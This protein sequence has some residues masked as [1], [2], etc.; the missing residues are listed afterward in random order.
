VNFR[1]LQKF[2]PLGMENARLTLCALTGKDVGL[3]GKT[4]GFIGLVDIPMLSGSPEKVVL[5][6]YVSFYGDEEGQMMILFSPDSREKLISIFDPGIVETEPTVRQ[7]PSVVDDKDFSLLD[8][9][10]AEL[11][12]IIGSSVLNAIADGAGIT[13]RP[14]PPV[15]VRDMAGAIL[16]SAAVLAP[17]ISDRVYVADAKFTLE[18]YGGHFEIVFMPRMWEGSGY[19]GEANGCLTQMT[20]SSW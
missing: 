7:H 15:L 12:N 3:S 11:A 18:G 16:E 1:D 13:L 6:S 14:S 2:V 5:S 8:S 20:N 9:T 17:G 19:A 4:Q 10:V